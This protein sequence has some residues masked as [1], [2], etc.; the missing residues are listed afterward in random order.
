M[1][2]THA[3]IQTW[4][5]QTSGIKSKLTDGRRKKKKQHTQRK[6]NWNNLKNKF[7]KSKKQQAMKK[8]H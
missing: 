7:K 3:K 5:N 1:I 4:L 6:I 2:K 8:T